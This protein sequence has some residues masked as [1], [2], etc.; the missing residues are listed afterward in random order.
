VILSIYLFI[1]VLLLFSKRRPFILQFGSFDGCIHYSYEGTRCSWSE[2]WSK[3][4]ALREKKI[5]YKKDKRCILQIITLFNFFSKSC[6]CV[7]YSF[8]DWI[9]WDDIMVIVCFLLLSL[10][11]V[12][13]LVCYGDDVMSKNMSQDQVW[14]ETK[15]GIFSF[16]IRLYKN[17][18][19]KIL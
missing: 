11:V 9:A 18:R 13:K 16:V 15:R 8:W 19:H 14:L 5:K 17:L 12:Y 1:L 10:K 2:V 4:R 6:H 3:I 7:Y